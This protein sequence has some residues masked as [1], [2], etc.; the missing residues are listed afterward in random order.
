MTFDNIR[1]TKHLNMRKTINKKQD[2]FFNGV[3]CPN[4][5]E[6]IPLFFLMLLL[7][8]ILNSYFKAVNNC[9]Q[10]CKCSDKYS[11]ALIA[12]ICWSFWKELKHVLYI[13]RCL[14]YHKIPQTKTTTKTQT[15]T[16]PKATTYSKSAQSSSRKMNNGLCTKLPESAE[17]ALRRDHMI[18][19]TKSLW[20]E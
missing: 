16:N 12:T 11:R 2:F 9:R 19:C 3:V 20:Q 17:T 5:P 13:L 7:V 14:S 10:S 15:K 1:R 6:R 18:P 8:N 4:F